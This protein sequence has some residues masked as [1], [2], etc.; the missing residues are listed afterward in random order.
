MTTADGFTRVLELAQACL[1]DPGAGGEAFAARAHLSR[2]HFDRLVSAAG[3]EAPGA[4]RRRL[5][6]ER[7]AF[8]LLRH[9]DRTV[10]DVAVEA[11][12]ASHEAFT[13]AFVRSYGRTPSALRKDPP[14]LFHHLELPAATGVH[15]Q[16][17][18]GLRLPATRQETSMDIVTHLV[19][20]HV[21]SLAAI[22]AAAADLP[23]AVLDQPITQSVEGV[24]DDPTLRGLI[25]GMVAQE[26]HWLNALRGEGWPDESDQTI[27]GLAARHEAAGADYRAFVATAIAESRMADTVVDTTCEPLIAHSIGG[28]VAHVITFGAVRRTMAVGAL[29]SAGVKDFDKADPRPYVDR[30]AGV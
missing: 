11:G 12:Y 5:L 17:P 7:A 20:H 26:E 24:D 1:D 3:G 29:W 14:L 9:R 21:E 28:I 10:L 27:S 30:L 4:L 13:R 19:D 22:I 23:D 25:N 18:G 6:L 15:F 8:H 2:F 16:P